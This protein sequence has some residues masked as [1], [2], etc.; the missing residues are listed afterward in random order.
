[1]SA[2]SSHQLVELPD[3]AYHFLRNIVKLFPHPTHGKL[4]DSILFLLIPHP[5]L[6]REHATSVQKK[7]IVL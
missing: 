7:T 2:L 6:K 4:I 1:M 5:L 3:S